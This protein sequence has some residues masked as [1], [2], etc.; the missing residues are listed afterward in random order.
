MTAGRSCMY[1][2]YVACCPRCGSSENNRDHGPYGH[3]PLDDFLDGPPDPRVHLMT[4]GNCGKCFD[5]GPEVLASPSTAEQRGEA[6]GR[7]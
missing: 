7:P 5:A 2:V 6:V 1:R 4:C 3:H